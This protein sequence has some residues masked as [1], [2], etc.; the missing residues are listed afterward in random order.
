[1]FGQEFSERGAAMDYVQ[2][3]DHLSI[4]ITVLD[5]ALKVVFWNRWMEEHSLLLRDDM[6]GRPVHELFAPPVKK[7]FVSKAGEVFKHGSPA[8]F[9]HGEHQW[10][11]PFV[12]VRSY[13]RGK[14]EKMEQTVIL[15]PIKDADNIVRYILVSV[16]DISDWV[17]NQNQLLASKKKFE[18]LS[19]VDGLTQIPNRRALME[20]VRRQL[21]MHLRKK[22]P[23]SLAMVEAATFICNEV[24]LHITVSFGV[25]WASGKRSI[26]VNRL[27][28]RADR[29]L[30]LAKE[31]GRNKVEA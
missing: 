9:S 1:M 4:G 5:P 31:R 25:G 26:R 15:S 14:L 13:L 7:V 27:L 11:F 28:G 12:T 21:H 22:R 23:L 19:L 29:S 24:P 8:F 16:F 17:L 10:V 2:F 6:L 30:Y 18:K 20:Q 3:F